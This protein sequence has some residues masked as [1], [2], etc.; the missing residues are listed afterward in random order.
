MLLHGS[1]DGSISVR[2][3]VVTP[4]SGEHRVREVI[5]DER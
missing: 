5:G 4:P 3:T 2:V 1:D